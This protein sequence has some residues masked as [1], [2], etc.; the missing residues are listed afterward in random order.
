VRRLA[1]PAGSPAGLLLATGSHF[2]G[3]RRQ[4]VL[5]EPRLIADLEGPAELLAEAAA[6][7]PTGPALAEAQLVRLRRRGALVEDAASADADAA[8]A[9]PDLSDLLRRYRSI[10]VSSVEVARADPRL[11]P[12]LQ[13]GSWWSASPRARAVR[14]ALLTAGP[15]ATRLVGAVPHPLAW[16]T[17]GDAAFWSGVRSAARPGEWRRWT[18]SSYSVLCYHRLAGDGTPGQEKMDQDPG[19]FRAQVR[20]LRLLRSHPLTLRELGAFHDGRQEVLPQ[21]SVLLTDDDGF[22]DAVD[23]LV[24]AADRRPVAFVPTARVGGTNPGPQP[25]VAPGWGSGGEPLADWDDLARLVAAG[26][27]VAAHGL[28]HLRLPELDDADLDRELVE[29]AAHVA[30]RFPGAVTAVAYPEGRYDLRVRDAAQRAGYALGFATTSGRNGA[31]TDPWCLSRTAVDDADRLL[32]FL[33]KVLT[34][35]RVPGPLRPFLLRPDRA[36]RPATAPAGLNSAPPAAEGLSE[37]A[38]V[39]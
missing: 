33:W 19:R 14:R 10:G 27:E 26:G 31:G 18:A 1:G 21:R 29:P 25:P 4:A 38:A 12:E 37:E 9:V 8:P 7:L 28:H 22:L 32:G 3:A 36:P 39:R 35:E 15:A 34:G 13:L 5:P 16:R 24:T 20:L 23:P 11:L 30:A 2:H 17:A 6:G